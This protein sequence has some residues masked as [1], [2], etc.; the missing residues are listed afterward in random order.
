MKVILNNCELVFATKRTISTELYAD[1][2]YMNPDTHLSPTEGWKVDKILGW[3][4]GDTIN[5]SIPDGWVGLVGYPF[6]AEFSSDSVFDE[7]TLVRMI[8]FED[9]GQNYYPVD[10]DIVIAPDSSVKTVMLSFS[11]GIKSN[12]VMT[13]K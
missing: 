4:N 7:S 6:I 12:L 1:G 11:K 2:K 5:F 9:V 10:K 8:N 3:N 13:V